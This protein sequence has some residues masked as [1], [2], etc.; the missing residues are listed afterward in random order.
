ML[1]STVS[2]YFYSFRQVCIA[3]SFDV[4]DDPPHACRGKEDTHG[5]AEGPEMACEHVADVCSLQWID[6]GRREQLTQGLISRS[7]GCFNKKEVGDYCSG[8]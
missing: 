4:A 2:P 1:Q 7:L 3:A 5:G 6:A 8:G